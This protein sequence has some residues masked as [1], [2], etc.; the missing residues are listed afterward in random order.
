MRRG[1]SKVASSSQFTG[2]RKSSRSNE[3]HNC[4]EIGFAAGAVGVR[5]TPGI[6]KV[7]RWPLRKPGGETSAPSSAAAH[8]M[9]VDTR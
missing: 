4:V 1:R 3:T 6:A 7:E 8:S 2:W 9:R 5:D